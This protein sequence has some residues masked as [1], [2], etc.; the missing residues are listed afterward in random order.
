MI[1]KRR[2]LLQAIIS[3]PFLSN[4]L[5]ASAH[6]LDSSKR[7][8]ILIEMQ[9]GNDGLNTVVPIGDAN[10]LRLRPQLA[11]SPDQCPHIASGVGLHPRMAGLLPLWK[12]GEM[13]IAQGLGYDNPNRSHF[14]STDIWASA[15]DA[16]QIKRS[17]WLADALSNRYEEGELAALVFGGRDFAFRDGSLS[18]ISLRSLR[19]LDT[20]LPAAPLSGNSEAAQAI[21]RVRGIT[22]DYQK[23]VL[24]AK[25][26][27]T[28]GY[29]DGK[30]GRQAGEA[31]AL[32]KEGLAPPIIQL[33]QN[34]YDTH[35]DQLERQA[36]LL[37]ELTDTVTALR[38]DLKEAN[39][40][41]NTLIVTLSE[42]GRRVTE[43][44]SAGTDHGTAAPQF[45]F[46]GRVNGGF[47]GAA[48]SLVDLQN[49]DLV[50]TVDFRSLYASILQGWLGEEGGLIN[51]RHFEALDVIRRS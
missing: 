43:N 47:H 17:G 24:R 37:N 44:G 26:Q 41:S 40:W 3:S 35:A 6:G 5:V 23:R 1:I 15:S 14:R 39:L 10:Y 49:D 33:H 29:P 38:R 21:N 45:L 19:E 11:L 51:G 12:S 30:L 46:G 2:Q 34:G 48:P 7:T 16:L 18:T 4:A 13:A 50:H 9:G 28:S 42:F 27:Q 32:L 22:I 8:L 36:D 25:L 20:L 31:M